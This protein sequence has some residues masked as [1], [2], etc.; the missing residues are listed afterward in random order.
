MPFPLCGSNDDHAH[1]ETGDPGSRR[2]QVPEPGDCQGKL[3]DGHNPTEEQDHGDQPAHSPPTS[4]GV[5]NR[6]P[7]TETGKTQE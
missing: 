6:Q 2:P 7:A 3:H 1:D 5:G 4:G